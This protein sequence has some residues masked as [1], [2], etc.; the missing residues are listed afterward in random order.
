MRHS[1]ISLFYMV[2][3]H[4]L[5]QIDKKF[6]DIS[7]GSEANFIAI[8]SFLNGESEGFPLFASKCCWVPS[9]MFQC[10][11]DHLQKRS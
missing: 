2:I 1:D 3:F 10:A 7:L 8:L 11:P 4:H 5:F 6:S 9:R